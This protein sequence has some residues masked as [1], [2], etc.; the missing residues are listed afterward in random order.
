[1]VHRKIKSGESSLTSPTIV[2]EMIINVFRLSESTT[3]IRSSI[4]SEWSEKI[5]CATFNAQRV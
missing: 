2:F 3:T 5:C 4:A 1:M